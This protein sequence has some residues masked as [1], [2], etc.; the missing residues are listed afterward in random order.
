MSKIPSGTYKGRAVADS[1]QYGHTKNGHEQI[2]IDLMVTVPMAGD[3]EEE[4]RLST[5][6]VFSDAAAP[7]A[8]ERLRACGWQ[9]DDLTDLR[10]I[11]ANEVDVT[12]KYEMYNGE[13]KLKVDILTGGGRVVVKDQMSESQKRAFAARLKGTVKATGGGGQ[14]P[15]PAAG[16]GPARF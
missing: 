10:G 1:A 4:K 16:N 6:L 3:V 5:F 9:G 12:V 11:D 14:A 15:A 7:Y 2:V 8:V 13:E